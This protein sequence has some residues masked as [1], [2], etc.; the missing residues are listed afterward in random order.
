MTRRVYR[1][2]VFLSIADVAA[3]GSTGILALLVARYLGP[4]LY[5]AYATAASLTELFLLVT[6][7]GFEEELT[8]RGGRD[9]GSIPSALR[10]AFRAIGAA[11]AVAAAALALFLLVAPYP[12]RVVRLIVL[13]ALAS[14][15]VRFHLPFRFI[16]LLLGDSRRTAVMQGIST[17]GLILLT[18]AILAAHGSV[19]LIVL[20]QLAVGIVV[21]LLW[22]RWLPGELRAHP[23]EAGA[24]RRF[25]RDA[26]PFAFSNLLWV[27]YFNFDTVLLSLLRSEREVGLYAGV[28]RI[29]GISYVLGNAL[30]NSFLPQLFEAHAQRPERYGPLARRLLLSMA[31]LGLPLGAA[32]YLGAGFIV[33]L[34]IGGA[35][36]DGILVARVLALAVFFRLLNFGFAGILMSSERQRTRVALEAGMLALNVGLNLA[37]IP[38]WGAL[39]AAAAT[40]AAELALT[41][42]AAIACRRLG[43][44][45]AA[46][47]RTSQ[48]VT[49]LP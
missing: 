40:V 44:R 22:L 2:A 29:V 49:V 42:A 6:G 32:L 20:A 34:L 12:G 3:K 25:V 24:L 15:V 21:L 39:G 31:G 18:V 14:I 23:P 43:E 46:R 9:R 35:F 17:A 13:M 10:L 5:G 28:Y 36:A 41:V 38:R 33:P 26:V 30:A 11:A 47:A 8:R 27:A 45:P 16:G 37:L 4:A 1:N 7:L 48:P 19:E